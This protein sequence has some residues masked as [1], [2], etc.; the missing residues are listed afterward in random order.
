MDLK[1]LLNNNSMS[2]KQKYI[3][4]MMF[5]D[6]NSIPMNST[7]ENVALGQKIKQ[8]IKNDIIT[9]KGFD[10]NFVLQYEKNWTPL[11]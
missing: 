10:D 4:F 5:A 9:L 7:E 6:P 11:P 3:A 2:M 8:L 1:A